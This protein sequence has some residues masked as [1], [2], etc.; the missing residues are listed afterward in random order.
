[1][2]AQGLSIAGL[3]LKSSSAA[4][5]YEW[6]MSELKGEMLVL[7]CKVEMINLRLIL[8]LKGRWGWV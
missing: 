7:D 5:I 4:M 1:M 3:S 2:D 8:R 6:D